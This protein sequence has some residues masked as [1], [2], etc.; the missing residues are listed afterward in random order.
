MFDALNPLDGAGGGLKRTAN[1]FKPGVE[2]LEDRAVP[3][4][5]SGLFINDAIYSGL[6]TA[7]PAVTSTAVATPA[8]STIAQPAAA[9][10]VTQVAKEVTFAAAR[11]NASRAGA[12]GM[13][14]PSL[15]QLQSV[16]IQAEGSVTSAVQLENLESTA[17]DMKAELNG[18]IRYQVGSAILQAAPSRILQASVGAFD[19]GIDLQGSSA[20]D[21]G[22]TKMDGAFNSVTLTN[23]A[24][25]ASFVGTGTVPVS[26]DTTA[27]SCACGSG[28]LMALVR[29][30]T[31][32]KVKVVYTYQPRPVTPVPIVTTPG[33]LPSK[34]FAISGLV[35]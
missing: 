20:K 34:I 22:L 1:P 2:S 26:Q 11:T 25:V 17:V 18:S 29:S 23:P 5:I 35:W 6:T 10:A 4:M 13:F 21:F 16:T 19:G 8:A 14:D 31:Q 24:D 7:A 3:A 30:T 9:A 27:T 33:G 32:G 28:N 12:V 15:G